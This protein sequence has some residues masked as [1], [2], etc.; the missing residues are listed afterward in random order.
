MLAHLGYTRRGLHYAFVALVTERNRHY[1]YG[2]DVELFG[3]LR[4]DRGRSRTGAAAH[5]GRYEHHLDTA[6]LQCLAYVVAALHRRIASSLRHVS[7]T[8]TTGKIASYLHLER[9][10]AF[11]QRLF[12][13]VAY[14][15][16]DVVYAKIVHILHSVA[17]A[18]AHTDNHY[19]AGNHIGRLN[20]DAVYKVYHNESI[21][22]C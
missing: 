6:T 8:Q 3:H 22:T 11:V 13:G 1:G 14:H 12:I 4:Y 17:A 2:K 18:T 10:G 7:R 21:I 9:N 5:T 16:H 20:I 15:E 19:L